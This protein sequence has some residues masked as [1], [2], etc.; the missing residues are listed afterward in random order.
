MHFRRATPFDVYRRGSKE[1]LLGGLIHSGG[2]GWEIDENKLLAT[3]AAICVPPH[4]AAL[5]EEGDRTLAYIGALVGEH[6][7]IP[8]DQ[9][10]VLGW[11]S[12]FPGAGMKLLSMLMAWAKT[13]PNIKTI[14]LQTHPQEGQRIQRLLAMRGTMSVVGVGL[15]IKL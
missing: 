7:W 14:V 12:C 13:Q 9:A 1:F 5:A 15:N 11:Y 2:A 10:I 4:F 3:C 8:G 6:P